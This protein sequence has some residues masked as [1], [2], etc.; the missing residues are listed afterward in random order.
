[1]VGKY[2]FP[3]FLALATSFAGLLI[4]GLAPALSIEKVRLATPVPDHPVFV[5]PILVAEEQGFWKGEGVEVKWHSL[6]GSSMVFKAAAAGDVDMGVEISVGYI[7]AAARG[8]P[9]LLVGDLKQPYPFF[10]WV[11]ADSPIKTAAE[12]KGAKIAVTNLGGTSYGHGR[13]ALKALGIEKEVKFVATGGIVNTHAGLKTGVIEATVQTM[14][15]MAPLKLKGEA[16][17]VVAIKDYMPKEWVDM[18]LWVHQ[19]FLKKG[20]A[21]RGTIKGLTQATDFIMKNPDWS[22]NKVKSHFGYSD[23]MA[24]FSYGLL[25]Y[26]KGAAVEPKALENVN[27]FLVEYGIVPK[28]RMVPVDK[29]YTN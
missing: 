23:Q 27:H 19:D 25:S 20:T 7:Q 15:A 13:L 10:I 4:L 14:F 5:L 18:V 16:R 22:I 21:I 29:L 24:K 6:R 2:L 11:R 8:V 1:M 3:Y 28:D 17:E 12:L 26:G 9:A